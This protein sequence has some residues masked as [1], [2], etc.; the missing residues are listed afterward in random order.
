MENC[1][2]VELYWWK[3]EAHLFNGYTYSLPLAVGVGCTFEN[4]HP[5]EI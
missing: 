3:F 5:C 2:V 4:D 1:E